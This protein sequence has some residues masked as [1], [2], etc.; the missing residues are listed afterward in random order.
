MGYFYA[1]G[2]HATSDLRSISRLVRAY[3]LGARVLQLAE[4]S[5][6][7]GYHH[8]GP[9]ARDYEETRRD[10]YTTLAAEAAEAGDFERAR[11]YVDSLEY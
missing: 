2:P 6:G 9:I 7:R 1:P 4:G 11:W 3:S 5:L 8:R 10:F